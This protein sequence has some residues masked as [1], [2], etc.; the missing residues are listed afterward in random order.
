MLPMFGPVLINHQFVK[1]SHLLTGLQIL[2]LL[3]PFK[4]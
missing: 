4:L 1:A 3:I 2:T